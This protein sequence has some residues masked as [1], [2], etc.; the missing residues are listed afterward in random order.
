MIRNRKTNQQ[1]IDELRRT[2]NMELMGVTFSR[3]TL[4]K[5]LTAY[6]DSSISR[7]DVHADAIREATRLYR[8]SWVNPVL[9]EIERRLVKPKRVTVKA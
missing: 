8:D 7:H 4:A 3:D 5:M 9:D 6:E 2:A 1:L